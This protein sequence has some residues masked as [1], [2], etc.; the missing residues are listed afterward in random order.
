MGEGESE[1]GDG[2]GHGVGSMVMLGDSR[3]CWQWRGVLMVAGGS[4]HVHA[5]RGDGNRRE[6]EEVPDGC[7]KIVGFRL[8]WQG[9]LPRF[10]VVLHLKW[11]FAISR[12]KMKIL[13]IYF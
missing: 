12:L 6:E 11:Y 9:A 13:N 3:V 7:L 10:K 5:L 8:I 2:L 4:V 1:K